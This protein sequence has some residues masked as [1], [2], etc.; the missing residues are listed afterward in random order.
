MTASRKRGFT[1]IE[2]LVVIAIIAILI[3]LL[4]PAV[5][6]A[7]EAARRSQC[8]NN[9]KQFGLALH[10]YHDTH[11]LLP[12]GTRGNGIASR[13]MWF[14]RILPFLEQANYYNEY[15]QWH[16][17]ESATG[18]HDGN[19]R[20]YVHHTPTSIAGRPINV[21]MCP[22]DPE[23][24]ALNQSR[25]QGN[26]VMSHGDLA[27]LRGVG[28]GMAFPNSRVKLRDV[29]DGTSNTLM[30][31]EVIIRGR[32]GS[33]WGSPGAYFVGGAHGEYAFTAR[34]TPN[35]PIPDQIYRCKLDDHPLAP[36]I[37]HTNADPSYNFA[38]S[39]HTG[40]VMVL[41][42]DGSV[43]F[44]SNNIDL[45]TWRHLATRAGHEVIGEF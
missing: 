3:A 43:R 40:G 28:T 21:A 20:T 1:L 42:A 45:L 24:P 26:Y 12:Y 17:Q 37:S 18:G 16:E 35:T 19:G 27:S 34:E 29:V 39:Y 22:S 4:L 30:A 44:V 2:L 9:L 11:S 10:N 7:R 15:W 13:D 32:T 23:G 25:F 5:Q 36:C 14:H 33:G 41:M 31:S 38:R 8:R 6:Q